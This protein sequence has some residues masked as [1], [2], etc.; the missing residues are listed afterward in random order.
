MEFQIQYLVL[1]F[2]FSVT[3]GFKWCWVASLHKNIQ[4]ML[5]SV[6]APFYVLHF[7]YYTSVTFLMMLSMILISIWWYYSILSVIRH[8]I[9]GN[10]L[11]WLLNL[12]LI[13]ET[14]WT[15]TRSG[16]LISMLGK[17]NWV[18]LTSLITMVLLMWKWMG[19]FWRKNHLLRCWGLP[20][21]LNWI[22]TLILSASKKT[23]ALICSVKFLSPEVALYL[24]ESNIHPCME[25]CCHFWAGTP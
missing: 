16:L 1:F 2:L 19:L 10:S 24:Y 22:G 12:K 11:N 4:L 3:D 13:Y 23:G 15:G 20:S 21:L 7:S 5:E 6:R 25:Y 8:L 9:F 18:H 17:L 14:Q